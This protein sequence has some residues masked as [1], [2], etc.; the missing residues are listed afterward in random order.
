MYMYVVLLL[1]YKFVLCK[2]GSARRRALMHIHAST[3]DR[4]ESS[5]SASRRAKHDASRR[6]DSAS[7]QD[8]PNS[9]QCFLNLHVLPSG[10]L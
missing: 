1:K 6:F 10:Y 3:L 5:V 9:G 8:E 7:V 2:N 4:L